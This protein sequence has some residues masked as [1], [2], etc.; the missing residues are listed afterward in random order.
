MKTEKHEQRNGIP[1]ASQL[2]AGTIVLFPWAC[3]GQWKEKCDEELNM[4]YM[5]KVDDSVSLKEYERC[6]H[7]C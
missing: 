3:K 6:M 7:S 2:R 4:R 1:V 5:Q